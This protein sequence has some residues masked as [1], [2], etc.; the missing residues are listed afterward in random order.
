ME[1]ANINRIKGSFGF[2]ALTI[3]ILSVLLVIFL[4]SKIP[5]GRCHCSDPIKSKKELCPFG[6]LRALTF[7]EIKTESLLSIFVVGLLARSCFRNLSLTGIVPAV[8]LR[9]RSPPASGS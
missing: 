9:S 4:V 2:R 3:S 5:S 6:A 8:D 1:N 7:V